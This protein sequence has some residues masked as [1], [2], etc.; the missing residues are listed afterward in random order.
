MY[1]RKILEDCVLIRA[2]Q[3]LPRPAIAGLL[4]MIRNRVLKFALEIKDE[5]G[6][7]N[8]DPA[9][10]PPE[11]IERSVAITIYGGNN[12]I[13]ETACIA[14]SQSNFISLATELEQLGVKKNDL[15]ELERVLEH[16]AIPP[17]ANTLDG[18]TLEW[19]RK[20]A[21]K[22]GTGALNVSGKV[23]EAVLTQLIRQHLGLPP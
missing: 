3:D 18:K 5:L 16:D 21:A 9:A 19:I 22:A 6:P 12:V 23:A 17:T 2:W 7:T 8:G 11:K 15:A 13:S 20:T 4:D 14:I 10:I 1:Q